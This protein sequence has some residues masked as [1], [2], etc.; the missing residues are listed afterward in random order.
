MP[1]RASCE[2]AG[3][4]D[5]PDLECGLRRDVAVVGRCLTKAWDAIH[6]V[7]QPRRHR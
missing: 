1:A 6:P 7:R 2:V 5:I 4:A 3:E